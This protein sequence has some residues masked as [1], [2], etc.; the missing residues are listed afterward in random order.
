MLGL[1]TAP[2][3]G[4]G[5]TSSLWA[6]RGHESP[7]AADVQRAGAA[8]CLASQTGDDPRLSSNGYRSGT[9]IETTHRFMRENRQ[10]I[11]V[12]NIPA[13]RDAVGE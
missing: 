1:A 13:N 4:D 6:V 7:G 11:V 2:N 8:T 10:G 9:A 3:R 5:G 12:P